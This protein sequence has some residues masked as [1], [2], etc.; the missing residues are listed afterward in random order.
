MYVDSFPFVSCP[1]LLQQSYFLNV[2]QTSDD[3]VRLP[4]IFHSG[5]FLDLAEFF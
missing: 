1:A 4:W 3:G 5:L 2:D